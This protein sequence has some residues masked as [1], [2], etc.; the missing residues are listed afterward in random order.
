MPETSVERSASDE[1]FVVSV[2]DNGDD[3]DEIDP[4]QLINLYLN[5]NYELLKATLTIT[6]EPQDQQAVAKQA[7]KLK[8][9][10]QKIEQDVLFDRDEA[11]RQW[12]EVKR[13]LEIECA[14]SNATGRRKTRPNGKFTSP[15]ASQAGDKT[16]GDGSNG[17][18][19]GT[20][21]DLFGGMFASN[22]SGGV[23]EPKA[24]SAIVALLD[25]PPL[26]AGANA[27]KLLEEI[28]KA[29]CVELFNNHIKF[30][31]RRVSGL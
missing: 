30:P 8:R 16:E 26:G 13:D 18:E 2:S 28:C 22:E 10:I 1:H 20:S 19:D 24:P 9:R 14:R 4:D 27:R 17:D 12:A 21:E 3:S 31:L 11:T 29:R 15:N 7:R 6:N 25:F 5:H 23:D